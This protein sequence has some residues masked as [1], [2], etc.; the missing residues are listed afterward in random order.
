M[1]EN[2]V[3]A[4]NGRRNYLQKA[5]KNYALVI[6]CVFFIPQT[7]MAQENIAEICG[8]LAKNK[9]YKVQYLETRFFNGCVNGKWN[10]AVKNHYDIISNTDN[11]NYN[12]ALHEAVKHKKDKLNEAKGASKAREQEL[13][14]EYEQRIKNSTGN[15]KAQLKANRKQE[16]SIIHHN[17][18]TELEMSL[19]GIEGKYVTWLNETEGSHK[20]MQNK[21]EKIRLKTL[22][23]LENRV[24]NTLEDI[25][26]AQYGKPPL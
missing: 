7:I 14:N 17:V 26:E 16:F 23:D 5:V 1:L 21:I 3:K 22:N 13:K 2:T 24:Y 12:N 10:K 15:A 25:S 20:Q 11:K 9:N 6:A 19:A 8:M 18:Q 4:L